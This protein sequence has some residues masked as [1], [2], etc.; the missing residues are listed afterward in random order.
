M[1]DVTQNK[2]TAQF[3]LSEID[4]NQGTTSVFRAPLAYVKYPKN[5]PNLDESGVSGDL[6][7]IVINFEVDTKNFFPNDGALTVKNFLEVRVRETDYEVEFRPCDLDF[8]GDGFISAKDVEDIY[9]DFNKVPKKFDLNNDGLINQLDVEIAQ[10]YIGFI[11]S[12]PAEDDDDEAFDINDVP[13]NVIPP[14]DTI[15]LQT[16]FDITVNGVEF[17]ID[18]CDPAFGLADFADPLQA[19][20][21]SIGDPVIFFQWQAQNLPGILA[22]NGI[23][24]VL[25]SAEDPIFMEAVEATLVI[26]NEYIRPDGSGFYSLQC[27]LP[28]PGYSSVDFEYLGV[29]YTLDF[30]HPEWGL[31]PFF[32]VGQSLVST[33]SINNPFSL[34]QSEG[35]FLAFFNS[36]GLDFDVVFFVG[37]NDALT[38]AFIELT[39]PANNGGVEPIFECGE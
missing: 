17:T 27:P 20:T 22:A 38:N 8:D 30:C 32:T 39:D 7:R 24:G 10:E 3:R 21:L 28:V 13:D 5:E 9:K 1:I 31:E 12:T 15:F 11:C 33:A 36:T 25:A 16:V 34:W 6:G 23:E 18:L 35:G 29:E 2:V 19:Y 14:P 37:L 4:V 26:R